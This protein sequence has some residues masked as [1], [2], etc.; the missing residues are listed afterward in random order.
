M[1]FHLHLFDAFLCGEIIKVLDS[2]VNQFGSLSFFNIFYSIIFS[3]FVILG[4]ALIYGVAFFPLFAGLATRSLVGYGLAGLFAWMYA[5]VD[6]YKSF[7]CDLD[8]V[9]THYAVLPS[10]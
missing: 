1:P 7:E 2:F 8:A 4:S 9:K 3:V 10:S 5:I 6:V